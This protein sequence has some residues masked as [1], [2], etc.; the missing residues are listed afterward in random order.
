MMMMEVQTYREK[1]IQE[2]QTKTTIANGME[3]KTF[4]RE[5]K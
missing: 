2:K 5:I 1:E 3:M 4:Q